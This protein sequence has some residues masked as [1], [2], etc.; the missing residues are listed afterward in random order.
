M[1]NRKVGGLHFRA[2]CC[3][4]CC[5]PR[6]KRDDPDRL[7]LHCNTGELRHNRE[8]ET[9]PQRTKT[10]LGPTRFRVLGKLRFN[11]FSLGRIDF[12]AA[13]QYL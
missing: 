10:L 5:V 4:L 8:A 12:R 9:R 1:H 13:I 2:D 11:L 7:A 3:E 6:R